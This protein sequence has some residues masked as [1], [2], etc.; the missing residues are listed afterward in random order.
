MN[1]LK[2]KKREHIP[3]TIK[4]ALLKQYQSWSKMRLY[5]SLGTVMLFMFCTRCV[6]VIYL[7]S[8][9]LV[10]LAIGLQSSSVLVYV[11]SALLGVII[12][13]YL[14]ALIS[15]LLLDWK[16]T[17]PEDSQGSTSKLRKN[18]LQTIVNDSKSW[19]ERV[20]ASEIHFRYLLIVPFRVASAIRVSHYTVDRAQLTFYYA[21]FSVSSSIMPM[22]YTTTNRFV[23][24]RISKLIG[25][26]IDVFFGLLLP[27]RARYL[28][29]QALQ[30]P[31]YEFLWEWQHMVTIISTVRLNSV[32]GYMELAIFVFPFLLTHAAFNRVTTCIHGDYI[33]LMQSFGANGL[34]KF[35]DKHRPVNSRRILRAKQ[36]A[37]L[38]TISEPAP[39]VDQVKDV[40]PTTSKANKARESINAVSN[41]L[42]MIVKVPLKTARS[43]FQ[44]TA[45]DAEGVKKL[46]EFYRLQ[47]MINAGYFL[48]GIIMG[49]LGI[50]SLQGTS[51][52]P[53][54][55]LPIYPFFNVGNKCHCIYWHVDCTNPST[56]ILDIDQYLQDNVPLDE[57]FGMQFHNCPFDDIPASM[58]QASKLSYLHIENS[59]LSKFSITP[60]TTFPKLRTLSIVSAPLQAIPNS[61]YEVPNQLQ[62]LQII[63]TNISNFGSGL[64]SIAFWSKIPF[65][66]FHSNQFTIFPEFPYVY[67][68]FQV[69]NFIILNAIAQ[70]QYTSIFVTTPFRNYL[71]VEYHA[72]LKFC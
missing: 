20:H 12:S 58:A 24:E 72:A 5:L 67:H 71:H 38:E 4:P 27:L 10:N 48:A 60:S 36:V 46:Q 68:S 53:E 43:H 70:R 33:I 25:G 11:V 29:Y 13:L 40:S 7:L 2:L 69:P 47:K 28:M 21:V 56:P 66:T 63:G 8:Q 22:L 50:V 34:W 54:C 39:K 65:M 3:H 15:M 45:L 52:P 30:A 44:V 16:A 32:I 6:I 37:P 18:T 55:Q 59:S 61:L 49:I 57:L 64:E 35:G 62:H 14:H 51:C 17:E 19:L 26:T 9:F 23:R 31:F 42:S 1:Y 41:K